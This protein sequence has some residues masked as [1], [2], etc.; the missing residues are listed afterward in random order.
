MTEVDVFDTTVA[1]T[2]RD[3][4]PPAGEQMPYS[5][6]IST[7]IVEFWKRDAVLQMIRGTALGFLR[8]GMGLD[9]S[10]KKSPLRSPSSKVRRMSFD[11]VDLD[12]DFDQAQCELDW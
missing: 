1:L 5:G 8:R 12:L 2:T 6:S 4:L 9:D 11:S 7:M 3:C 10:E